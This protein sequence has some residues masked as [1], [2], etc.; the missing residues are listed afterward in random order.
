[1]LMKIQISTLPSWVTGSRLSESLERPKVKMPPADPVTAA[2]GAAAAGAAVTF[3]LTVIGPAVAG[4]AVDSAPGVDGAAPQAASNGA[5]A[6]TLA[7][8]RRK[9]RRL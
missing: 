7:S 9:R 8:N 3:W 2:V 1:M 6:P 4:A 5:A